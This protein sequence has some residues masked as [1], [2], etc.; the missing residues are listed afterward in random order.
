[1]MGAQGDKMAEHGILLGVI[2]CSRMPIVIYEYITIKY[3]YSVRGVARENEINER[4]MIPVE[5]MGHN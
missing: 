4:R 1:M 3:V 2:F 5:V